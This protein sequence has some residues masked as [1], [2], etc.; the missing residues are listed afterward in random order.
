MVC[1]KNGVT[2]FRNTRRYRHRC[3]T[4]S[5]AIKTIMCGAVSYRP[6]AAP[7]NTTKHK[8]S[9]SARIIVERENIFSQWFDGSRT[10]EKIEKKP[11]AALLSFFSPLFVTRKRYSRER[12]TRSTLSAKCY[13]SFR[14]AQKEP[15]DDVNRFIYSTHGRERGEREK[16]YVMNGPLQGKGRYTNDCGN[17]RG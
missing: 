4:K 12:R 14:R 7:N 5:S 6:N 3:L 11:R 17:E 1:H 9:I 8:T 15:R 16:E 2:F 10:L 13:T